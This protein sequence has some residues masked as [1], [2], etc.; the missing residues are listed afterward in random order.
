[1]NKF[2]SRLLNPVVLVTLFC[3]L[4]SY[5]SSE[6]EPLQLLPVQDGGRIKPYDTFARESLQLV[7]GKQTFQSR[8]AVEVVTT[9][10]LVPEAWEKKKLFQVSHRGL[11]EALKLNVEES[12]FDIGSFL[13][14]DR[15]SFV[16]QELQAKQET[17]EKLDPYFQAVQRLQNQLGIFM[18]IKNGQVVRVLPLNS[19]NQ[20]PEAPTI[21]GTLPNLSARYRS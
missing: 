14:N 17:K 18:A 11:K 13:S 7:Y 19:A 9:W 12:Y 2:I 15:I 3:S 1:M 10:F 4:H 8:P 16:F 20:V 6:M 5:A 21:P